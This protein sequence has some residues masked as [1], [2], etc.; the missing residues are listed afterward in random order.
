MSLAKFDNRMGRIE[1]N[2]E[3]DHI[4]D[5][6]QYNE[7]LIWSLVKNVLINMKENVHFVIFYIFFSFDMALKV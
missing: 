3:N 2:K 4:T 7:N 6:E 5:L 1:K